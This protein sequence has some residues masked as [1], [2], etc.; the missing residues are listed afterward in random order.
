MLVLRSRDLQCRSFIFGYMMH[1]KLAVC[2]VFYSLQG[3]VA[4]DRLVLIICGVFEVV[5]VLSL[6]MM[7]K[8]SDEQRQ[9][10]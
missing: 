4:S 5:M 2:G 8:T 6:L 9:C 10:P 3:S 1:T 7:K